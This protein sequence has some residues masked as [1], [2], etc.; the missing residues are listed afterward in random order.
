MKLR[1]SLLLLFCTA[2]LAFSQYQYNDPNIPVPSSGYGSDGTHSV[3]II[4]FPNPY[5][6]TEDIKI[7][8]P[9]DVTTKVPTLFYSHAYG[10][11]IPSHIIGLLNFVAKKGYAL[12]FVPYQTTG[13]SVDARYVNLLAGFRQ[14]ARSYSNIIDTSKVGFMGHSFGGG[15]SIA[16]AYQCFTENNWGNQGRYIHASAPWYAYNISQTQLQSFPL[17]TKF[18]MEVYDDDTVNDH[19]MAIDIFSNINISA[20]EKDFIT[21]KASTL[22]G[23]AYTTGHDMPTTYNAFDA[24]DYYAYYRLIDALCDYTFHGNLAGKAVAL[25]NGGPE[26]VNMPTGLH[27]LV[28]TD[29]PQVVYPESKYGFPCSSVANPR[30][31]YCGLVSGLN[32]LS[33][34]DDMQVYPNPFSSRIQVSNL[35]GDERFLLVDI[36]GKVHYT[37]KAATIPD[38]SNLPKGMY[39]LLVTRADASTTFKIWKE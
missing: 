19:R 38:L 23:Y 11:N 3:G 28:Q 7:Y 1:L 13:V 37:G 36:F 26:Q 32:D 5:F 16:I 24:L 35:K 34:Q 29:N 27:P 21:V 2:T 22:N 4:S 33:Q 31:A 10:G 6:S 17:D 9:K 18:L 12:V 39:C 15:A 8:Y 20:A 25:G 30:S 14:A